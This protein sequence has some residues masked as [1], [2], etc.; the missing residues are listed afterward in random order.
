MDAK[1]WCIDGFCDTNIGRRTCVSK[2]K[3]TRTPQPRHVV[4]VT[5]ISFFI[6]G[7]YVIAVMPELFHQLKYGTVWLKF[8]LQ[9]AVPAAVSPA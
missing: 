5:A 7:K 8:L 9:I 3:S 1:R 6:L 4:S 2:S